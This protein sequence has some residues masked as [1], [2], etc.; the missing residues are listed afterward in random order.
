MKERRLES[1]ALC[2]LVSRWSILY[3]R[4][5]FDQPL[6]FDRLTQPGLRQKIQEDWHF[7]IINKTEITLT[8]FSEIIA[9]SNLFVELPYNYENVDV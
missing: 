1:S 8:E 3:Y 4:Q 5:S 2:L 9:V 6:V 7:T